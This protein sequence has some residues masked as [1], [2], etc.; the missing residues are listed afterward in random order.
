[1]PRTYSE[2]F[3]RKLHDDENLANDLGIE[4]AKICVK[5]NIPMTYVAKALGVTKL[6]VFYWFRGRQI[7]DFRRRNVIRFIT[8][9]EHDLKNGALPARTMVDAKRYVTALL[10]PETDAQA[11][12]NN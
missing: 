3:L 1:M 5:A 2:E 8:L 12:A 10:A 7:R 6:T 9:V 11:E 4:L